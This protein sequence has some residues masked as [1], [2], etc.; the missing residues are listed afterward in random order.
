MLTADTTQS[1]VWDLIKQLLTTVIHD[2]QGVCI[3]AYGGSG[4]GKTYTLTGAHPE[5]LFQEDSFKL[6]DLSGVLPRAAM[7]ICG[8]KGLAVE[9]SAQEISE[10]EIVT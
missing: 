2:R 8:Q 7:M 4:S 10:D 6:N 3:F 9:I 5:L 1:D